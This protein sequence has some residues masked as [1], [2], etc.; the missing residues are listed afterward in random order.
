[1]HQIF[2]NNKSFSVKED[3]ISGEEIRKLGTIPSDHKVFFQLGKSDK[4]I[5]LNDHDS[6]DLTNPSAEYFLSKPPERKRRKS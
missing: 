3:Y 1:M 4:I 2:I 6:V 5:E